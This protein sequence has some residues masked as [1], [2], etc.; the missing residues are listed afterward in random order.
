MNRLYSVLI[1]LAVCMFAYAPVLIMQAPYES[2]MGLVQKI[3]YFHVPSWFGD[4]LGGAVCGIGGAM[5][6]LP[7]RPAAD[8]CRWRRRSWRRCSG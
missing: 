6:L 5:Y 2:T 1:V 8:R 3:F 4:V 7:A